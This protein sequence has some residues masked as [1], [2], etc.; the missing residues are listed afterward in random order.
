MKT[1]STE[2]VFILDRSG[3][4]SGMEND[5]IGGFN[6]ML[7]KQQEEPGDCRITTVL[8][9]DKNEVLHDRID[10]KA[11]REITS[12]E[13]FVRGS[14]ALL[15]AI[16]KAIKKISKVQKNTGDEYR[17][18]KYYSSLQQTVWRM[19]VGSLL[20]TKLNQWSK[21]RRKSITGSSFF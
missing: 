16:G 20:T 12:H 19:P 6:S 1:K 7:K 15:D 9:D 5:T 3:S 4:M 2:L 17:A 21:N 10:I 11:V 8:F 13:Y 18:K 14:T